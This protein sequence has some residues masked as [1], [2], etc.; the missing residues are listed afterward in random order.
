MNEEN[1]KLVMFDFDGVL[2]NTIDWSFDLHKEH[3][4]LFTRE[5]FNSFTL[6]NFLDGMEKAVKEDN[7]VVPSDWGAR[8]SENLLHLSIEDILRNS[9]IKLSGRYILAIV[10]SSSN[11]YIEEFI[12]KEKISECFSDISGANIHKSKVVKIKSLL[13]K[14]SI[15]P[16][17]AV[18][19]T[20]TLGDV[21]E[22]NECGVSSIGV[23]WGQHDKATIS[24]GNPATI[25]ENPQDL[26]EAVEDVLK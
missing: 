11:Q 25:I 13:D 23:L 10:S 1:R 20:D 7:H 4:P 17:N 14:Y 26:L 16:S 3:N 8:Y 19:I 22:A 21:R 9:I 18:F 15:D 6:G 2:V 12:N 24:K 5:K